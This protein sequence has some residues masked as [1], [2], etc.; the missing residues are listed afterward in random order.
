VAAWI[1]ELPGVSRELVTSTWTD[2]SGWSTPTVIAANVEQT[3]QRTHVAVSPSGAML[4]VWNE[5]RGVPA[6]ETDDV[7]ARWVYPN[8]DLGLIQELNVNLQG[9]LGTG[10]LRLG[11]EGYASLVWTNRLANSSDDEVVVTRFR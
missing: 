9:G 11:P 8:G 6:N 10:A 4:V 2:A 3:A 1:S 5:L 7:R